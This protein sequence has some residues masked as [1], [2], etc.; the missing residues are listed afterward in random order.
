[1]STQG[2]WLRPFT[3]Q[4]EGSWKWRSV[5]QGKQENLQAVQKRHAQP[6]NE[7]YILA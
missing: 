6:T 4:I 7:C 5:Y 3:N 1:M 2:Q